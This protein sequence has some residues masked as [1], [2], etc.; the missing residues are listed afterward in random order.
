MYKFDGV[1]V[2]SASGSLEYVLGEN[3]HLIYIKRVTMN[4]TGREARPLA[5]NYDVLALIC[6][7]ELNEDTLKVDRR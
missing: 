3:N 2:L 1:N 5:D 7:L 4:D 6:E